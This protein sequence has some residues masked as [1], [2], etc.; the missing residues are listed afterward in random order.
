MSAVPPELPHCCGLSGSCRFAP[1]NVRVT[2]HL[3]MS[4]LCG[5]TGRPVHVQIAADKVLFAPVHSAGFHH[6]RSL[7][8][9]RGVTCLRHR[10][11]LAL[12]LIFD[13]NHLIFRII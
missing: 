9:I 8:A 4:G 2:A 10:L 7:E 6:P 11:Y 3:L 13:K 1:R 5:I 12:P